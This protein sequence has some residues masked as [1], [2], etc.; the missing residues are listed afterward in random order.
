VHWSHFRKNIW[1]RVWINCFHIRI[2]I[3]RIFQIF[4]TSKDFIIIWISKLIKLLNWLLDWGGRDGVAI[5]SD[6]IIANSAGGGLTVLEIDAFLEVRDSTV[7]IG[8][9]SLFV[10]MFVIGAIKLSVSSSPLAIANLSRLLLRFGCLLLRS[11]GSWNL[12]YVL[13]FIRCSSSTICILILIGYGWMLNLTPL[14]GSQHL[15]WICITW[16]HW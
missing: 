3:F 1:A 9:S 12:A 6:F 8:L 16:K 10:D 11:T 15:A 14:I 2:L 4:S 13:V 5:S 7:Q